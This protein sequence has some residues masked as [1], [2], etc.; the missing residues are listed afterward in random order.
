MAEDFPRYRNEDSD[1]DSDVPAERSR[2]RE[3]P[4]PVTRAE[5]SE[6]PAPVGQEGTIFSRDSIAPSLS[7]PLFEFIRKQEQPAAKAE[8]PEMPKAEHLPSVSVPGEPEVRTY[9]PPAEAEAAHAIHEASVRTAEDDD[10]EPA[11]DGRHA[12]TTAAPTPP[13]AAPVLRQP[14]EAAPRPLNEQFEEIMRTEMSEDYVQQTSGD[15]LGEATPGATAEHDT[16]PVSEMPVARPVPTPRPAAPRPRT[17]RASTEDDNSPAFTPLPPIPAPMPMPQQPREAASRT[18]NEQFD[19]I[20]STEMDEDFVRQ[21]SGDHLGENDP[22][23]D[24]AAFAPAPTAPPEVFRYIEDDPDDVVQ[25]LNTSSTSSSAY[26]APPP[27]PT[28]TGNTPPPPPVTPG[29]GGGGNGGGGNGGGPGG[30][31][32]NFGPN[33]NG[34]PNVAQNVA[35]NLA[36]A[37]VANPLEMFTNPNRREKPHNGRAFVA[38]FLTGWI[39]KNHLAN[40]KLKGVQAEH[41][42][43]NAAH[44]EQVNTLERTQHQ[45]RQQ[46]QRTEAQLAQT[47]AEQAKAQREARDAE[48]QRL[49][50]ER[51]DGYRAAAAQRLQREPFP[52]GTPA[53]ERPA[54]PVMET[55][56]QY[57]PSGAEMPFAAAAAGAGMAAAERPANKVI[58]GEAAPAAAAAKAE[59][60]V[61][62]AAE[63]AQEAVA[64]A[65]ELQQGEHVEHATGGGHNIIVDKHGHAVEGAI[66]YGQEFRAQQRQEQM[67]TDLFAGADTARQNATAA[68]PGGI[69]G[70]SVPGQPGVPGQYG[71]PGQPTSHSDYS[72][73]IITGLGSGQVPA[74]HN[75]PT[76]QM[77]PSAR[78]HLLPSK[79]DNPVVAT[80]SSP[81]L[82]AAGM[83]LVIAF[84]IAALV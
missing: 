51:E 49:N 14:L 65:Y 3:L 55:P 72:S 6:G 32:Y 48:N 69:Q 60:A 4:A 43:Q 47:Q 80:L 1:S 8:M 28:G 78:Q 68:Q 7:R 38:G 24:P 74:N 30:F 23:L 12:T 41:A 33:F 10:E 53:P 39:I 57:A 29:Y 25:P 70:A 66:T 58:A 13:P 22:G 45:E 36:P 15:R 82:W 62:T 50:Q 75:L 42:K 81:W 16:E 5:R 67:R 76:G 63:Q 59:Q 56:L 31:N 18:T 34:L 71:Q 21:A 40:K 37:A 54:T 27:P 83:V 44:S 61:R 35:P 46:S 11:A 20:M 52:G 9:Q 26:V 79:H 64:K 2:E 19:E 17:E 77:P 84:F 73:G